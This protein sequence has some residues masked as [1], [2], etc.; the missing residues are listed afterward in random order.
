M[1]FL[2][3]GQPESPISCRFPSFPFFGEWL[4]VSYIPKCLYLSSAT[5]LYDLPLKNIRTY[6]ET[7]TGVHKLTDKHTKSKGTPFLEVR[8]IVQNKTTDMLLNIRN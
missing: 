5:C 4:K 1:I 2:D 7:T 6:K 8:G 3:A